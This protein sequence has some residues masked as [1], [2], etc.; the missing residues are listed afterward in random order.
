MID[1]AEPDAASQVRQA[2]PGMIRVESHTFRLTAAPQTG[3][4]TPDQLAYA[5]ALHGQRELQA[6]GDRLARTRGYPYI[7]T[8]WTTA[9]SPQELR[10]RLRGHEGPVNGWAMSADGRTAASPPPMIGP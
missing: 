9:A 1:E 5:A 4:I 6:A 7:R 8:Q 2:L 3:L 10:H